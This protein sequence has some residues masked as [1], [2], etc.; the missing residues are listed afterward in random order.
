MSNVLLVDS[1]P[2]TLSGATARGM[3]GDPKVAGPQL[4]GHQ[5]IHG[6]QWQVSARHRESDLGYHAYGSTLVVKDKK[7]CLL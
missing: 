5:Y 4:K 7:E 3:K 1:T 6:V 2:V